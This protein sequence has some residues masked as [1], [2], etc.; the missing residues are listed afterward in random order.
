KAAGLVV[1]VL[2]QIV[3]HH[4]VVRGGASRLLV[5]GSLVDRFDLEDAPLGEA[6]RDRTFAS[7]IV[8]VRIERLGKDG[9]EHMIRRAFRDMEIP[10]G[11]VRR[12]REESDGNNDFVIEILDFCIEQGLIA[13]T[14]SGW[15]L[16]GAYEN[17]QIPGRVRAALSES[18]DRLRPGALAL[19]RAFAVLGFEGPLDVAAALAS[20]SPREADQ[21]ATA[22]IR[23]RLLREKAEGDPRQI[24]C[25]VHKSAREMLYDSIPEEE[26]SAL[27]AHAGELLEARLEN[28]DDQ[29]IVDLAWHFLRA[30]DAQRGGRYGVLAAEIHVRRVEV[31]RAIELYTEV[32]RVAPDAVTP[33]NR[34]VVERIADLHFQTGEHTNVVNSIEAIL[35]RL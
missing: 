32:A 16:S 9:I 29:A 4:V 25:F 6:L 1:E 33:D 11:F 2:R 31:V 28:G 13:R 3:V 5:L 19:A 14:R 30:G 27:H 23:E 18:I 10:A 22:L 12:V 15:V 26:R 8:E 35:G 21:G 17:E 7:S 20:L 24:H 34:T